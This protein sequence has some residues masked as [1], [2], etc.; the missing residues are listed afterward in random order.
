MLADPERRASYALRSREF[1][2][3]E[4]HAETAAPRM[5]AML[6]RVAR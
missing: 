1:F 4:F 3:A 6:A 5:V 2:D